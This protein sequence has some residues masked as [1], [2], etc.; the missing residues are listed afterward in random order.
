MGVGKDTAVDALTEKFG[1]RKVSFAGPIYDILHYAQQV[2]GF[3]KEKD[4]RFLQWV[5]SEWARKIDP[6]VWI[7][8]ALSTQENG[9]MFLS[10]LRFP[11]E[12]SSAK[13][14]GWFCVKIERVSVDENREG[15]GSNSHQS[16]NALDCVDDNEWDSVISNNGSIEE[17]KESVFKVYSIA[18]DRSL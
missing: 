6:D 4:R 15:T 10:D 17:F 16:E 2:C 11:N 7:K 5:G 8:K 12:L 14:A 13:E 3:P 9:N 1:G 18:N